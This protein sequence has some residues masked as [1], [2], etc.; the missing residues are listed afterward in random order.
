MLLGAQLSVEG[1]RDYMSGATKA[2]GVHAGCETNQWRV[3]FGFC[4]CA[5]AIVIVSDLAIARFTV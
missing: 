3:T 5:S 4:S 2:R 1:F